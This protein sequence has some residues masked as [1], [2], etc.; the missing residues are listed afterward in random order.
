MLSIVDK[1]ILGGLAV[2]LVLVF[3]LLVCHAWR[4]LSGKILLA[5]CCAALV[6]TLVPVT[7][8]ANAWWRLSGVKTFVEA[9]IEQLNAGVLPEL[10]PKC[11][12]LDVKDIEALKG[13]GLPTDYAVEKVEYA[14]DHYALDLRSEDGRTFW[15]MVEAT[16]PSSRPFTPGEY[17][18]LVMTAPTAAGQAD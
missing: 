17:R 3:L 11:T 10:S 15:C 18:L 7:K 9:S 16:V 8:L 6:V 14:E 4:K 12:E 5:V 1:A 13:V 2:E